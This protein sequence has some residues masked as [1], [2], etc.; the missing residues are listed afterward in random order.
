MPASRPLTPNATAFSR[1]V[2]KPN[3]TTRRSLWASAAHN[4]PSGARYSPATPSAAS[5]SATAATQ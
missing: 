2:S 3:S 1:L 4:T 5:T